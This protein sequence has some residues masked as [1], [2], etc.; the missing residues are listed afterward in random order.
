M[1]KRKHKKHKIHISLMELLTFS[2]A[3]IRV[4]VL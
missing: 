2:I 3:Y 4:Y 1:K